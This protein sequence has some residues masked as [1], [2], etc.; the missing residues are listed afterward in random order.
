VQPFETICT[1]VLRANLENKIILIFIFIERWSDILR[2]G[3]IIIFGATLK[4]TSRKKIVFFNLQRVSS[5]VLA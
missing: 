1:I 2:L 3:E 4:K 5:N